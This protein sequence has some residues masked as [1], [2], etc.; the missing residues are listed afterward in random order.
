MKTEQQSFALLLKV[1][2]GS[3]LSNNFRQPETNVFVARQV[4]PVR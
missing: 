2:P 4:D 3:T 1:E